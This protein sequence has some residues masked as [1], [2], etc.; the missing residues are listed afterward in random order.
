[1]LAR[2]GDV[3]VRFGGE[4]KLHATRACFAREIFNEFL[5]YEKQHENNAPID[6]IERLLLLL[7]CSKR[8]N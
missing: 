5:R 2:D 7:C 6:A 4:R 3:S 1:M 8:K